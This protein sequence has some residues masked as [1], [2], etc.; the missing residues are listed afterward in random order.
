MY[1]TIKFVADGMME[2]RILA[3]CNLS[4][5]TDEP[6]IVKRAYHDTIL[7]TYTKDFAGNAA[8]LLAAVSYKVMQQHPSAA[9]VSVNDNVLLGRRTGIFWKRNR[10]KWKKGFER[11]SSF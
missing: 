3:V 9:L 7:E 2:P 6:E 1:L 4:I 8:D 5:K 11:Q 10:K